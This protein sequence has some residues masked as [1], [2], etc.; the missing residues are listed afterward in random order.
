MVNITDL[1]KV[2]RSEVFVSEDRQLRVIHLILN[3][4]PLSNKFQDVGH[5]IRA[6][7]PRICR[8]DVT[9]PRFPVRENVVP[10]ELP[11]QLAL[12]EAVAP[13]EKTAFSHL[14]LEEEIDQF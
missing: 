4:E 1:N 14:S 2:L 9:V 8:I 10:V 13:R 6:G 3:F 5:A 11:P 12:P 7:D